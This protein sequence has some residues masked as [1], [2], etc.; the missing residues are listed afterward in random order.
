MF[1]AGYPL[2]RQ[3][4]ATVAAAHAVGARV[5]ADSSSRAGWRT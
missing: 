4:T 2:S 3:C 1:G 5:V